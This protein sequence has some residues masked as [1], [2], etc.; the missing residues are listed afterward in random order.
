MLPQFWLYWKSCT[1][2]IADILRLSDCGKLKSLREAFFLDVLQVF[3][4]AEINKTCCTLNE[5]SDCIL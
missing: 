1:S 5:L 4:D 3:V 2:I